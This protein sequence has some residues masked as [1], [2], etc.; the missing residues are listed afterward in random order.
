MYT[1]FCP[2]APAPIDRTTASEEEIAAWE[3]AAELSITTNPCLDYVKHLVIPRFGEFDVQR[4]EKYGGNKTYT[5]F[6]DVVADYR[7]GA[8]N[9]A[10]VKDNLKRLIN[11]MI[12]PVRVHFQTDPGARDL[13]ARVREIT[14]KK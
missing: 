3:I 13:L 14:G 6:D 8:L 9:P 1:A 7:S 10:D 2:P 11:V 12:E 4:P 5:A